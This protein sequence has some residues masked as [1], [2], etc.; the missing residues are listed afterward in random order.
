MK[1][2]NIKYFSTVNGDGVRTA[3]FVSGC[4]LNP[5]CPGCFNQEAWDF[6]AGVDFTDETIKTIL[7]SIEP[8]YCAGLSILG[9]EPLAM[10]NL[11]GI[12]SLI[13]AFKEKFPN[14]T[15]W[16]WSGYCFDKLNEKQRMVVD[17]CDAFVDGPFIEALADVNLKFRG[18]SN[19]H[20]WK[21]LDG[22]WNVTTD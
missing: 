8:S 9:G 18:S 16:I 7:D 11:D 19:Q 5:H 6:N 1:Y 2:S 21:R 17:M 15:I 14:K 12:T 20:I 13:K 4:D 3:L 22:E 10:K